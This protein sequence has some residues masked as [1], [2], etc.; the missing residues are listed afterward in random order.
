MK[1]GLT[2][3]C[4]RW[5]WDGRDGYDGWRCREGGGELVALPEGTVCCGACG[6]HLP[7]NPES[8][9]PPECSEPTVTLHGAVSGN[10]YTFSSIIRLRDND[11]DGTVVMGEYNH[12]ADDWTTVRESV[13]DI[14]RKARKAWSTDEKPWSCEGAVLPVVVFARCSDSAP[15]YFSEVTDIYRGCSKCQAVYGKDENGNDVLQYPLGTEADIIADCAEAS[16]PCCEKPEPA[17]ELAEDDANMEDIL[18]GARE[19][20][21]VQAKAVNAM[22]AVMDAMG[23][24]FT[25]EMKRGN[26]DADD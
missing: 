18:A 14:T 11:G 19:M 6:E 23:E 12:L 22:S 24:G 2:C 25:E 9:E 26:T 4:G 16:V 10:T 8:N 15:I 20:G 7:A 21:R 1:K 3:N 5:A 17:T 13:A